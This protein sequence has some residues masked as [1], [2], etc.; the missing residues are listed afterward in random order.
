MTASQSKLWHLERINLLKNLSEEE[1]LKLDHRTTVR[2]A[3]KNDY[4]YF[5]DEP[6]KVLFFLKEGRIKIGTFS[7]DGKEIIKAILYP[8]EIFGE[9]GII[10]EKNRQDFAIAMDSN[11]RMCTLSIEEF[12][13]LMNA[14]KHLSYAVTKNIGEKLRRVERRLESLLFKEAR[15]RIVDFMKDMA[16]SY[17][18]MIGDE[19]L[20]KHELTHQEIANLTATSRQTVTTVLNDLKEKDII[21]MER[22]R[23]LIRDLNK[24]A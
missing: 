23:F 13:S 7:K 16:N 14:N 1:M 17:G 20:V 11:T 21:Y 10:G 3:D 15:E 18:K 4:I 5:P 24:L 22:K 12:K 9:M 2:L 19:V 6:S 8:G